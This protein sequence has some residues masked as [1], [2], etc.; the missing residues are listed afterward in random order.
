MLWLRLRKVVVVGAMEN[1]GVR[2]ARARSGSRRSRSRSRSESNVPGGGVV[3]V[4]EET[5]EVHG[6]GGWICWF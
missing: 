1:W 5:R 6:S 3:V 4:A 2:E